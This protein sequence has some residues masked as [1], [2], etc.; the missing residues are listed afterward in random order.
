MASSPPNSAR[1]TH[2]R[3][4][5]PQALLV[6]VPVDVDVVKADARLVL[7]M[8]RAHETLAWPRDGPASRRT[9]QGQGVR[10]PGPAA[11]RPDIP[12]GTSY[13]RG[14]MEALYLP[15]LA[16]EEGLYLLLRR[17]DVRRKLASTQG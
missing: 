11:G 1:R 15:D 16:A 6:V 10:G 8:V 5:S 17:F 12:A 14:A 3:P 2:R 4:P 7:L 13:L 9:A